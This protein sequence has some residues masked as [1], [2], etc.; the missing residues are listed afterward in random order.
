MASSRRRALTG[1]VV[2]AA[3]GLAGCG[4]GGGAADS[5]TA[6]TSTATSISDA[7]TSESTTT[8]TAAP[9]E[10]EAIL[11]AYQGYWDTWLAAN[12]PPNPDHPDLAKY[13]TGAA[14]E[15]E[16]ASIADHLAA[17]RLVRLPIASISEHRP[18]IQLMNKVEAL[19]VD[20]SI[21][22]GLLLRQSDGAVLDSSVATWRYAASLV[23]LGGEWKVDT[24]RVEEQLDG[25]AGCAIG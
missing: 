10:E 20:C 9:T 24:I 19:M 3:V 17:G 15:N 23:N 2:V 18:L 16:R 21:D 7:P 11:A 5:A 8:T 6:A 13:A 25:I 14:L 12:D 1:A 4:G 22:D